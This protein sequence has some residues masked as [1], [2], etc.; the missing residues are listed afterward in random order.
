MC[1]RRRRHRSRAE[2]L[3]RAEP[4]V[5]P[6]RARRR[7]A[8]P[9]VPVEEE[10]RGCGP[11][12]LHLRRLRELWRMRERLLDEDDAVVRHLPPLRRGR[13][14]CVAVAV[15]GREH[16]SA[17]TGRVLH[18]RREHRRAQRRP[19]RREHARGGGLD[20][21]SRHLRCCA[22]HREIMSAEP[23]H[24]ETTKLLAHSR[25]HTCEERL[26]EAP[27]H[28]AALCRRVRHEPHHQREE[29]ELRHLIKHRRW[30][31]GHHRVHHLQRRCAPRRMLILQV[32][33]QPL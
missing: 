2:P 1:R 8:H 5:E 30:K 6:E 29:E 24:G 20:A 10:V 7:E 27:R 21:E 16:E 11:H 26:G 13:R 33:H 23:L 32:G 9:L 14:V 25:A 3:R 17:L 22:L 15:G 28:R 31:F 4:E 19:V 12:P 18:E